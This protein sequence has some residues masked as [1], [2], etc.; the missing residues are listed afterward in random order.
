V[1]AVKTPLGIAVSLYTV[2]QVNSVTAFETNVGPVRTFGD[3][4]RFRSCTGKQPIEQF[5]WTAM[6][7]SE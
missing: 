7:L 4:R 2:L 1:N 6:I 5:D 3:A